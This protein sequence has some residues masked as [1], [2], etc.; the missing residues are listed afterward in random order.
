MVSRLL[1]T[2]VSLLACLCSE[3]W[4]HAQG[5]QTPTLEN[6]LQ[7]LDTNLS[8]YD[9]HVPSLFCDEHVLSQVK[10]GPRSQNTVTDSVFRLKRTL[11]V[12]HTTSLEESREV[13]RVDGK[14]AASQD[15]DGPN[16]L[17][18][19]FEGGLA[20]ISFQQAACMKY[21]LQK[22]KKNRPTAPYV[23][24]FATDL[25]PVNS[26]RCLLRENSTGRALIDPTTMQVKRLE[27]TTP[28]HAIIKGDVYGRRDLI[29]DYAPVVLGGE[30]FW[31][32]S[33]IQMRVT[34]GSGTFH[35]TEWSFQAD[36]RNYHKLQVTSHIVP[37][38]H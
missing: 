38:T 4:L 19:V 12:D 18:G 14:T 27:L 13:L 8:H 28:H 34:S 31:M 29:V 37:L 25:T 26:A 23:I 21:S 5:A 32:P 17:T 9:G 33:S 3:P 24:R 35:V 22:I 30:A 11:N 16:L 2:A 15:L 20:V 7:R 36:Y 10:P 6:I 1:S